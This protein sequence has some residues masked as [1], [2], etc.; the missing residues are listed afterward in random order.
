MPLQVA[1]ALLAVGMLASMSPCKGLG[2]PEEVLPMTIGTLIVSSP[3]A[4][5]AK[6]AIH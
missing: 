3:M 4:M 5:G 6:A 1:W 2:L